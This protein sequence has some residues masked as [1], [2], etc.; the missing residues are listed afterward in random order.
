MA[1]SAVLADSTRVTGTDVQRSETVLDAGAYRYGYFEFVVERIEGTP[2]SGTVTVELETASANESFR[3]KAVKN[4]SD[5]A[6]SFTVNYNDAN[7]T[8]S[9]AISDRFARFLRW[10]VSAFALSGGANYVVTFS[11]RAVLKEA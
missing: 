1:A 4:L 8:L 2:T 7:S 10:K 9:V 3:W 6:I 11:I 5:S